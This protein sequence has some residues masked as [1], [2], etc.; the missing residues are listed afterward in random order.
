M[1]E[2]D[3]PKVFISYSWTSEAY[4][5]RVLKLAERLVNDGVDVIFDRW[6]LRPGQDMYAFMEQSIRDAEKVLI[7]CEEGYA[8]KADNRTGGVGTE[9]QIITPDVYGEYKQEK[10]IPIIM[11]IPK[12][13]PSYL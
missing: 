3:H 7:L 11:E 4:K 8:K 1:A 13:V 6:N 9:T 10:F 2:N 5:E 12:A